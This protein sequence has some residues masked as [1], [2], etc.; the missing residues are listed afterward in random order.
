M[1]DMP[2]PPEPG[3]K[4]PESILGENVRLAV[5]WGPEEEIVAMATVDVDEL[6]SLVSDNNAMLPTFRDVSL[7]QLLEH[8]PRGKGLMCRKQ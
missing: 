2:Y 6:I 1:F 4:R 7:T 3:V 8:L 5:H